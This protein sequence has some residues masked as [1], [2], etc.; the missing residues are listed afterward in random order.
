MRT[1]QATASATEI[2]KRRTATKFKVKNP[3]TATL[4][5]YEMKETAEVADLRAVNAELQGQLQ[6][7]NARLDD[8]MVKARHQAT[9]DDKMHRQVLKCGHEAV[10]ERLHAQIMSRDED[11]RKIRDRMDTQARAKDREL[12]SLGDRVAL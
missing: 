8:L 9:Q 5:D 6:R 3:V 11:L 12:A 7:L 2:L 10:L 4:R 1:R